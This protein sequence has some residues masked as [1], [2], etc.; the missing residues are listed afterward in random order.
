MCD[1]PEISGS[2]K[3]KNSDDIY[4]C[5][6]KNGTF[7]ISKDQKFQIVFD[8]ISL[9]H[10]I[11]VIPTNYNENYGFDVICIN[12]KTLNFSCTSLNEANKWVLALLE[13]S[14][15]STRVNIDSFEKI[16][17]IG[18][19]FSSKVYTVRKKDTGKLFALKVIK[20]KF[21]NSENQAL[22][23]RN[24]LLR[25]NSPFIT[26]IIYA[27]QNKANFYFVF[28]LADGGD[29]SKWVNNMSYNFTDKQRQILLAEIALAL[30]HI[31]DN[32][33]VYRDLKTENI[34]VTKNGH[35]KLTDFGLSKDCLTHRSDYAFCGSYDYIAPEMLRNEQY[36]YPVDWWAFGV[37]VFQFHFGYYPF[38]GV[39]QKYSFDKIIG[40]DPE[41]PDCPNNVKDL[42]LSLLEKDPNKRLGTDKSVFLHPY[43]EGINLKDISEM[44][45]DVFFPSETPQ[46]R[47]LQMTKS[48]DSSSDSNVPNFSFFIEETI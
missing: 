21:Q 47:N 15:P 38:Q 26:K 16:S 6:I 35:I 14:K 11:N 29:I 46:F 22:T 34:L 12:Q 31:H 32:G 5:I 10:V 25:L 19:G 3:Y 33:I 37:I 9:S 28:D 20:K 40:S 43:F 23:E 2:L 7:I 4:Y 48:E 1:R 24:A 13:D 45:E 17:K 36:S 18:R 41:I 39:N 27:F 44:K 42:I 8:K 30:Q